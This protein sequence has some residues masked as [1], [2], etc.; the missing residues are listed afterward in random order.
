MKIISTNLQI[1]SNN[2]KLYTIQYETQESDPVLLL[3]ALS[4]Y[5]QVLYE[6]DHIALCQE[7]TESLGNNKYHSWY[8]ENITEAPTKEDIEKIANTLADL[9]NYTKDQAYCI[10]LLNISP[11]T[12]AMDSTDDYYLL[13]NSDDYMLY[14][15]EKPDDIEDYEFFQIPYNGHNIYIIID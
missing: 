9:L 14:E 5:L 12:L 6:N 3:G 4:N 1:T 11:L 13:Y 7:L 8:L 10:T 2:Q 15:S